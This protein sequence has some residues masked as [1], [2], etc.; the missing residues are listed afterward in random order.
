MTIIAKIAVRF[1]IIIYTLTLQHFCQN[2]SKIT[3]HYLRTHHIT[4]SIPDPNRPTRWG[5]LGKLALTRTPDP[6]QL[7]EGMSMG[8]YAH[9]YLMGYSKKIPFSLPTFCTNM[10]VRLLTL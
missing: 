4:P 1:D 8:M 10:L 9:R 6:V 3:I 7:G 5:I 2:L